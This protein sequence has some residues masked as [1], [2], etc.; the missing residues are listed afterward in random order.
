MILFTVALLATVCLNELALPPLSVHLG[1]LLVDRFHMNLD[2]Y[3]RPQ[4]SDNGSDN[5]MYLLDLWY[6]YHTLH[7][8]SHFR[9]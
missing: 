9:I 1:W 4:R 8:V 7:R 3:L 6:Q 2:A 5:G